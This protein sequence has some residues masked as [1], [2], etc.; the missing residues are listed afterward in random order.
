MSQGKLEQEWWHTSHLL[1]LHVNMNRKKGSRARDVKEFHPFLQRE[2]VKPA[3]TGDITWL[4]AFLPKGHPARKSFED[5]RPKIFEDGQAQG[6][7]PD[8]RGYSD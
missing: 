4:K 3:Q 1:A 2:K 5:G 7:D 6:H 8:K